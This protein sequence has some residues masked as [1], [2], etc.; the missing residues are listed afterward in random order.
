MPNT[1]SA[2]TLVVRDGY[3][4]LI[5]GADVEWRSLH[6]D[7]ATVTDGGV[8]TG[9]RLGTALIVARVGSMADTAQVM[10]GMPAASAAPPEPR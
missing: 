9:N 5:P 2:L 6:P 3:G 10:F 8:V 4:N 7:L 1:P